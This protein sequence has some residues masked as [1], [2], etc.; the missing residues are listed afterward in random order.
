MFGFFRVPVY[1]AQRNNTELKHRRKLLQVPGNLFVAF[2]LYFGVLYFP[3]L[4][5][6]AE[7]NDKEQDDNDQKRNQFVD[8]RLR[9]LRFYLT[10]S[11]S[12]GSFQ[13]LHRSP[14]LF[15]FA[16]ISRCFM[17]NNKATVRR[18][19]EKYQI[20]LRQYVEIGQNANPRYRGER[21][22]LCEL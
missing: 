9:D 3:L 14:S 22:G 20:N 17:P 2:A 1:R 16:A 13:S 19:Q 12:C 8:I 4:L 6:Y 18:S 10:L 7:S 21:W 11:C 15:G 5:M